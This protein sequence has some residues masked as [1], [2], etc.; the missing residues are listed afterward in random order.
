MEKSQILWDFQ[1]Q[2]HDTADFAEKL[3]KLSGQI[4]LKTI[5]KKHLIF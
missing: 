5:V 4:L 3:V 1:K 2:I